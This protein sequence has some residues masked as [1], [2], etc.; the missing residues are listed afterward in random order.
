MT[1][2]FF[3]GSLNVN[4]G[5]RLTHTCDLH[6]SEYGTFIAIP[7]CLPTCYT[8][9]ASLSHKVHFFNKK[10]AR[11]W[12]AWILFCMY[13][14]LAPYALFVTGLPYSVLQSLRLSKGHKEILKNE[15]AKKAHE[16]K[17]ST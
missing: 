9:F 15:L 13:M 16:D 5:V 3:L 4:F 2:N 11:I 10:I 7:N 12:H 17:N 8:C 14:V 1:Y 6:S